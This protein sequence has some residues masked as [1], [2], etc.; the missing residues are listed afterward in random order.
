MV[1]VFQAWKNLPQLRAEQ[2]ADAALERLSALTAQGLPKQPTVVLSDDRLRLLL[3][4]RNFAQDSTATKHLFIDTSLLDQDPSYIFD[5]QK[6]F[7]GFNYPQDLRKT[8]LP[9]GLFELL[10]FFLVLGEKHD[11][12]YI[13][14]SF[15][16][17]F[18]RF[19]MEPRG[20]VYQLKS[21]DTNSW[22]KPP[23]S[24]AQIAE[25]Q[26]IWENVTAAELPAITNLLGRPRQP[27]SALLQY[28]MD[29]GHLA[30]ETNRTATVLG[31]WYSRALDYWGVELQRAG[32]LP[33]AGKAFADSLQFNPDSLSGRVNLQ[34]NETLRAGKSVVVEPPPAVRDKFGISQS[35]TSVLGTDGPFDEPGF[36][37]VL[38]E[39]FAAGESYHEGG[40]VRGGPANY[41]QAV[42]QFERVHALAPDYVNA[43]FWLCK[44]F[45]SFH[46]QSD[47][48]AIADQVLQREPNNLDALFYQASADMQAGS[49]DK[50]IP[51]LNHLLTLQTNSYQ[52]QLSRAISY[53]QISN[54]PSAKADY[55]ALTQLDPKIV[56]IRP[57]WVD[58]GLQEIAYHEK[59]TN[60]VIK[61]C[62]LYLTN[63]YQYFPTN[64]PEGAELKSIKQRLKEFQDGAP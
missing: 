54:Y 53:L 6:K 35:W 8:G 31:T 25:N 47:A 13:H 11:L 64:F 7:P 45:L 34:F 30:I 1:P 19:Y 43:S 37:Y 28:F 32:L 51:P 2:S 26:K 29:E 62:Q 40:P 41:L 59:D 27:V 50:A 49:Y 57:Y 12:Y 15:G 63:Y 18:E 4:Q 5:L 16:L 52:A 17:Y 56:P 10:H 46:R 58:Y 60:D 9:P 20:L 44:L 36:C 61:Y 42:Q 55:L 21:Y 38:G 33:E 48:L 14:P 3:L 39:T 24:T 23:L 22:Q